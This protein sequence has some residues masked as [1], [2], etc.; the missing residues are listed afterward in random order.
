MT[1]FGSIHWFLIWAAD[2]VIY[3]FTD[4]INAIDDPV[5]IFFDSEKNLRMHIFAAR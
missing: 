5:A 3:P 1:Q 4:F 2:K